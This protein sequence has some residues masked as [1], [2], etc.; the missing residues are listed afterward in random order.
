MTI[1]SLTSSGSHMDH[2]LCFLLFCHIAFCSLSSSR[3][4]KSFTKWKP[5]SV[6]LLHTFS[7]EIIQHKAWC[8]HEKTA[9]EIYMFY[10][11]ATLRNCRSWVSRTGL[12][13]IHWFPLFTFMD[14][15]FCLENGEGNRK[16]IVVDKGREIFFQVSR[17]LRL[18]RAQ[19]G[20]TGEWHQVV[21]SEVRVVYDM[22]LVDANELV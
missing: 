18:L 5:N 1:C 21:H 3:T 4:L 6:L 15:T 13:K 7:N 20:V 16:C 19:E 17:K 22:V 2:F 14:L 11:A 10:L 12:E 8:M 9:E